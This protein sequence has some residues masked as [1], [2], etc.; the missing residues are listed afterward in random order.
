ML[1]FV[2]LRVLCGLLIFPMKRI[3]ILGSTGSIGQSTLSVVE[4][5]PE[6]FQVVSLAAGRNV[7][8]AFEQARRWK[9]RLIS[10][11]AASDA[12]ILATRLKKGSR[13]RRRSHPRFGWKRA[14]R[15][16]SRC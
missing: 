9:P 15:H 5:H 12:E 14:R 8:A 2:I 4:S 11:A 6:R 1:T 13:R 7:D 10:M 3:A 16:P